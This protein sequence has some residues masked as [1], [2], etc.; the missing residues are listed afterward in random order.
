[1]TI[2]HE[3]TSEDAPI[4][5]N[6]NVKVLAHVEA[7]VSHIPEHRLHRRLGKDGKW[8]YELSCKI[9]SVYLSASTKYTLL[10]NG[11]W[12]LVPRFRLFFSSFF[13]SPV[14]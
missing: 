3:N 5:R 2:L 7:D 9:E 4:V 8:Y 10:Y 6:E 12:S 11:E 1:M 13:S 14:C